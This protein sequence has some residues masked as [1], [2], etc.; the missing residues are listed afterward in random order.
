MR[1]SLSGAAGTAP[2]A[3]AGSAVTSSTC[4][5]SPSGRSAPSHRAAHGRLAQLHHPAG[6]SPASTTTASK[7]SP[8]A[9]LEHHRLGGVDH[10]PLERTGAA[11]GGRHERRQ[12][13]Q[14]R[15]DP[16]R[17]PRSPAA[18][19][20]HSSPDVAVGEP[21]QR[22]GA[23]RVRQRD[24]AVQRLRRRRAVEGGVAGAAQQPGREHEQRRRGRV[25]RVEGG[26]D[27]AV[28]RLRGPVDARARGRCGAAPATSS[29]GGGGSVRSRP[30]PAS[31]MSCAAAVPVSRLI[32]A[33]HPS[34]GSG[35]RSARHGRPSPSTLDL[36]LGGRQVDGA[37]LA[38]ALL[39][40]QADLPQQ[41]QAAR[42]P[43][44]RRARP[45]RRRSRAAP[46]SAPA[47]GARRWRSARRPR[48][49]RAATAAPAA[50]R[51]AAGWPPRSPST[52][53]CRGTRRPART[54][55]PRAA[56][57]RRRARSPG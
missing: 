1:R 39:P 35:A 27:R 49:G 6:L 2:S 18:T 56:R 51:R 3:C 43:S 46:A 33:F 8:D 32:C 54:A 40:Q 28:R 55:S 53:G 34:T 12:P 17:A 30:T 10:R 19:A 15:P 38:G 23:V 45:A 57:P 50:D 26:D 37:A 11:G 29:D 41:L 7:R 31:S 9:R 16:L 22:R 25:G 44:R 47:P 20:R 13:R 5:R 48:R 24:P 36:L 42:P 14:R 4:T 52:G 21:A